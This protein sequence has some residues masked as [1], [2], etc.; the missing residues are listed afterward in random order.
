[1]KVLIL[2]GSP[3]TTGTVAT[4]LRAVEE[5]IGAAA[6][7]E[8]INVCQLQIT[9]CVGCME[10]RPDHECVLAHDDA[11]AMVEKINAA[12]ALVIGTPTYWGNMSGQLKVLFD[13]L[14]PVFMGESPS[15]MPVPRQKGKRGIIVAACTTPW[16]FSS[17]MKQSSGAIKAI[18]EI[19]R[20]GGYRII[21]TLAA[22]NTKAADTV[23]AAIVKRAVALGHKLTAK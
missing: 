2:N 4:L 13:R 3:R 17:L 12:D 23:P 19:L 15:G 7:V 22:P 9:P 11:H 10:C 16:P 18:A 5:G 14:V 6:Q 21:G 8:W 20:Y 1:M